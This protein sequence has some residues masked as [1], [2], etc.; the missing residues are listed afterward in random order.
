MM[1]RKDKIT[2]ISLAVGVL[3][4]V[5][6][7]VYLWSAPILKAR[8]EREKSRIE[9]EA[10]KTA[11]ALEKQARKAEIEKRMAASQASADKTARDSR[12]AA[13]KIEIKADVTVTPSEIIV[14]NAG[15]V[16]W[17][18]INVYLNSESSGYG[19]GL[20]NVGQMEKRTVRLTDFCKPDGTR[21]NPYATKVLRIFVGGG[22]FEN[23]YVEFD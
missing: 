17:S 4:I 19:V 14:K 23:R 18:S 22:D 21:F 12:D 16:T 6:V 3:V 10:A 9:I 11:R 1:D 13:G 7:S 15:P 20:V 5:V 2:L 8:A